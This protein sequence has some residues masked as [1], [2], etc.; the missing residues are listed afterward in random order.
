LETYDLFHTQ[1]SNTIIAFID[2]GKKV[3]HRTVSNIYTI[4]AF[5]AVC[6]R[7]SVQD[8]FKGTCHIIIAFIDICKTKSDIGMLVWQGTISKE[9]FVG[10]Y[11]GKTI[12]DLVNDAGNRVLYID[13]HSRQRPS[14]SCPLVY[15]SAWS[16][17]S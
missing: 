4:T 9:R 11:V 6:T 10:P 12:S 8:S 2:V 1:T 15:I 5:L 17:G 3:G 7:D 13:L 16:M 14:V